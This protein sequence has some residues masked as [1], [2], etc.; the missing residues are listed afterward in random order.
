M[1]EGLKLSRATM[2]PSQGDVHTLG[3]VMV[4]ES[5]LHRSQVATSPAT[6]FFSLPESWETDWRKRSLHHYL[7]FTTVLHSLLLFLKWEFEDG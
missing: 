6:P 4:P 1:R 3:L 2:K 7:R 5:G